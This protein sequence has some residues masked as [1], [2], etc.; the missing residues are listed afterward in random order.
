MSG[1]TARVADTQSDTILKID[2]EDIGNNTLQEVQN[3]D[4]PIPLHY[5]IEQLLLIPE[6]FFQHWTEDLKFD[7]LKGLAMGQDGKG[8]DRKGFYMQ[9]CLNFKGEPIRNAFVHEDRY[10]PCRFQTVRDLF[11]SDELDQAHAHGSCPILHLVLQYRRMQLQPQI[12]GP[13]LFDDTF[14]KRPKLFVLLIRY[15]WLSNALVPHPYNRSGGIDEAALWDTRVNPTANHVMTMDM[16][17]AGPHTGVNDNIP[18]EP[19]EEFSLIGNVAHKGE[20]NSMGQPMMTYNSFVR[21]INIPREPRARKVH[22]AVRVVNHLH[23]LGFGNIFLPRNIFIGTGKLKAGTTDRVRGAILNTMNA[24]ATSYPPADANDSMVKILTPEAVKRWTIKIW[25]MP[26]MSRVA[27]KLFLCD[28]AQDWNEY[29]NPALAKNGA[30]RLYVEAHF[31]PT[32]ASSGGAVVDT[33]VADGGDPSGS[34]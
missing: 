19:F 21:N 12:D 11:Y 7:E 9:A 6:S 18:S 23:T 3:P 8:L 33:S 27:R 22:L 24:N 2:T 16:E 15:S 14:G 26:Q 30:Y 1:R 25:V 4:Q 17:D 28:D 29:I 32:P 20:T 5:P 31:V 34:T 13:Q 10:G